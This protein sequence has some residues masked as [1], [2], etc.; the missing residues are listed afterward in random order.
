MNVLVLGAGA[1]GSHYGV[2]LMRAGAD[3]T[4]LVRKKRA[5]S[6]RAT[7]LRIESEVQSYAGPVDIVED[8][9]SLH[10][11]DLILLTC[12]AFD[13][14]GAMTAIAPAVGEKTA[15]LPLLNGLGPYRELDAM[16]GRDRVLGG[17]AYV[18]LSLREDGVVQQLGTSDRLF[19]GARTPALR[20]AAEDTLALLAKSPGECVLSDQIDQQL[21]N[22]WVMLCAGAAVTSLMRSSIGEILGTTYGRNVVQAALDECLA[23][24]RLEGFEL[25]RDAIA[26]IEG[27]LLNPSSI[28]MASMARD[29]EAGVARL[30]ADS[31]VGDMV[32][33]GMLHGLACP[34]LQTAFTHL[35]AYLD[36][37]QR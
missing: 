33:R 2:K 18:A 30:E 16:F 34:T 19:I 22:K 9:V 31:I 3:V 17:V 27:M 37:Q 24:A 20:S 29:I 23:V 1:M 11:A 10:R 5:A 15:I 28:W 6:L 12:K 32:A 13:L 14:P 8:G 35:Q 25:Q 26:Q 36:R 7:G 4:F 21:W